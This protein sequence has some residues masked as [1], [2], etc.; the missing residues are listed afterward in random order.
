VPLALPPGRN[1]MSPKLALEYSTGYGNGPFGLGWQLAVPAITVKT[2]GGIPRYRGDDVFVLSGAEDLVQVG[3][4]AS[5]SGAARV[6][7]RQYRPRTEGGFALIER[8]TRQGVDHWEAIS[9]DG[10]LSRFGVSAAERVADPGDPSRV[11]S[12]LL[13][14]SEDSNGNRIVYEYAPEDEAG[15]AGRPWEE[16]RVHAQVY[17]TAVRWA[18]YRVGTSERFVYSLELDYGQLDDDGLPAANWDY[19]PD[20]FSSYAYGFDLRTARRCRRLFVKVRE[21]GGRAAGRPIRE[22]GLRYLDEFSA[23]ERAGE[24]PP[25]NGV[26]LLA[27]VSLTGHGHDG[28][29]AVTVPTAPL[30]FRYTRWQPESRRYDTLSA[31]EDALPPRALSDPAY[32]LVDLHGYGLPDVVRFE[33]D[34]VLYWRNKGDCALDAPHPMHRAPAGVSLADPGVQFADVEGTGS[35]ALLVTAAPLAGYYPTTF[36]AEWDPGS[37]QAYTQAPTVSLDDPGVRLVDMDGDGL[38][39]VL[40]TGLPHLAVYYNRGRDGFDEEPQ[41]IP[42]SRLEAFP[43]ASFTAPDERLR[44]AAMSGGLQDIVLIHDRSIVYWPNLGHGRFGAPVTMRDAPDLPPRYDPSRLFLADLDGDGHADLVYVDDRRV[45]YWLNCSGNA[46]SERTAIEGTP[47]LGDV[48]SVRVADMKGSGLPGILWSFDRSVRTGRSNL[49]FLEPAGGVKPYLLSEIDNHGGALTRVGYAPS[50]RFYLED[51]ARGLDWLTH[52]PFPLH[53]VERIEHLDRLASSRVVTRYRY[54]H[55]CWDG[56]EREFRGFGRVDQIDSEERTGFNAGGLIPGGDFDPV[57]A[58]DFSPPTLTRTWFH[59]GLEQDLLGDGLLARSGL[60]SGLS[61]EARRQ[62]LRALKG[63]TLR[64]ELYAL[65]G[66]AREKRPYVVTDQRYRV[67]LVWAPQDPDGTQ[68]LYPHPHETVTVQSER[69]NEPRVTRA[70]TLFDAVGNPSREIKIG[71]PRTGNDPDDL[72]ATITSTTYAQPVTGA[73]PVRDRPAEKR[74]TEPDSADRQAIQ[75]YIGGGGE[76]DWAALGAGGRLLF[77]ARDYYDG[78]AFA[79]LPLGQVERGNPVRNEAL[80]FDAAAIAAAYPVPSAGSHPEQPASLGEFAQLGYVHAG[81]GSWVQV[82]RRAFD[83]QDAASG[84]TFGLIVAERDPRGNETRTQF[85]APY[86]LLPTRVADPAGLVAEAEYDFGAPG[87]RL[88]RDA[89]GNETEYAYD[90]LGSV[91]AIAT[92]GKFVNGAWEGDTL[93]QPTTEFRL[94]P[95]AFDRDGSPRSTTTLQRVRHRGAAVNESREFLD[96]LGRILERRLRLP[97]VQQVGSTRWLVSGRDLRNNK[98]WVVE[99][100]EARFSTTG[101]YEPS[102]PAGATVRISYDPLGRVTK[103]VNPDGSHREVLYAAVQD[104][105]APQ[106]AEPCPWEAWFYDENDTGGVAGHANTPR[107]EVYDAWSRRVE[108]HEHLGGQIDSTTYSFDALGRTIEMTDPLGR[109]AFRAVFDMLGNKLRLEQ[110]DGGVRTFVYD[111]AGNLVEH[112]DGRGARMR[113]TF[114]ALN[115]RIDVRARDDA[116][117]PLTLRERYSYDRPPG[118]TVAQARSLNTLGREVRVYDGAGRLTH[119]GYDLHGNPLSRTRRVLDDGVARATLPETTDAARD[120]LL[121]PGP[122]Y[123]VQDEYDALGKVTA[124]VLPDG[125]RV[126]RTFDAA[127]LPRRVRAQGMDYVAEAAYNAHGQREL[128]RYGNGAVTETSYDPLMFRTAELRTRRGASGAWL[129]RLAYDY[130]PVGN[131]TR[132]EDRA[133]SRIVSG[134][135]LANNTRTYAYDALYRLTMA[136]GREAQQVNNQIYPEPTELPLRGP[137]DHRA[138]EHRYSYDAAGNILEERSVRTANQWTRAYGYLPASNRL[139]HAQPGA[140][141]TQPT[142]SWDA[143]GNLTGYLTNWHYE[144][145]WADR[146]LAAENKVPGAAP[147]MRADYSYDAAGQRVR[148]LGRKGN[149]IETTV[150]IDGV[151]EERTVRVAGALRERKRWAHVTDGTARVAT[152]KTTLVA[153]GPD[154]EP[155]VLYWHPD[156]LGSSHVLTAGN[157]A[158]FNQEEYYPFGGT[159]LGGYA[160]KRD[161]FTGKERDEET[162]F[163]YHGARYYMPGLGRWTAC[164]PVLLEPRREVTGEPNG[165]VYARNRPAVATDPTGRWFFILVLIAIVVIGVGLYGI[166]KTAEVSPLAKANKRLDDPMTVEQSIDALHERGSA[167]ERSAPYFESMGAAGEA[168]QMGLPGGPSGGGESD[169]AARLVAR[170]A[171]EM[172]GPEISTFRQACQRAIETRVNLTSVPMTKTLEN[173]A[174]RTFRHNIREGYAEIAALR[175]AQIEDTGKMYMSVGERAQHGPGVYAWAGDRQTKLFYIDIEVP[176]GTVAEKIM[177]E[178]GNYFYRL[179]PPEGEELPVKVVGTNIPDDLMQE[180]RRMVENTKAKP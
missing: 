14:E 151:F 24:P 89:N 159:S 5:G 25:G 16:N 29:A 148:K 100:R 63:T 135:P 21:E 104:P 27:E 70:V 170:T 99:Q 121:R 11:A 153:D 56:R 43:N 124:T 90:G 162:G 83:V 80:A 12:W 94:D 68:V 156:H 66:S 138:Y 45:L 78:A 26:S 157:G 35:A 7:R 180:A 93:A 110:V 111:A 65:D 74:I 40:D 168:M 39:D 58:Q 179:V 103:T 95:L 146:M 73:R 28:A 118:S 42:R 116:A 109:Y 60:P 175:S 62:A 8:V 154:P 30:T 174:G 34:S 155:A 49:K 4:T 55:G 48:G 165:Y 64:T 145:D 33:R 106:A 163:A 20:P 147:T 3:E 140:V 161:R 13:A 77:H 96:G 82:R 176:P 112:G 107:R 15:L 126:E 51:R 1:G 88:L 133:Q 32:E 137:S 76:P 86:R 101:S 172:A 22:Y 158:F 57:P 166:S 141:P 92:K 19:R 113:T 160:R 79:G 136:T 119:D 81:G 102:A 85:A 130:D 143:N 69:G 17:L 37:F 122:G 50:T 98:G 128:V 142:Y 44:L 120:A 71:Q 23:S 18:N 132:V 54:S 91:V 36:D 123:R 84:S 169:D 173:A 72:L 125:T 144:W 149:R 10:I 131:V 129:Q 167:A 41:H 67:E 164:D 178:Q 87:V 127:G 152:I 117:G 38:S 9:R 139:R 59:V 47:P 114:D 150:Y 134:R 177:D 52:L 108:A 31:E 171:D 46:W 61:D 115:R 97:P 53:V 105:A 6:V 75:A 2:E